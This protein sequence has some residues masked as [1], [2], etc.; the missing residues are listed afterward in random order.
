MATFS[1]AI[2]VG[3]MRGERFEEMEALVDTGA[4]TTVVPGTA[5]R[6][7]GIAPTRRETFEYAGGQRVELDMAEAKA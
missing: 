6:R 5:L 1:V 2:S 7:L 3:D 4:T